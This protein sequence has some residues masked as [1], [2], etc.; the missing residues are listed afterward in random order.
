MKLI[1]FTATCLLAL[2][3]LGLNLNAKD[4]YDYSTDRAYANSLTM[5]IEDLKNDVKYLKKKCATENNDEYCLAADRVQTMV[6]KGDF[7]EFYI[8]KVPEYCYKKK[9]MAA[10]KVIANEI[11]LAKS[12]KETGNSSV[13]KIAKDIIADK[14]ALDMLKF[15]CEKLEDKGQCDYL[16]I[17]YAEVE[18]MDNAKKYGALK[19]KTNKGHFR[20]DGVTIDNY[21]YHNEDYIKYSKS[22]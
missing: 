21:G 6:D 11:I 2:S 9:V 22:L 15:G 17:I 7:E 10:C 19:K 5:P 1:K 18:D 12:Y 4:T 14:R 13:A 3:F 16:S 8:K 20:F